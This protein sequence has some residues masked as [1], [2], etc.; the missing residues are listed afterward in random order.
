MFVHVVQALSSSPLV[1]LYT[2]HMHAAGAHAKM[3]RA[4]S[5]GAESRSGAV[6][7]AAFLAT[8]RFVN[9]DPQQRAALAAAAAVGESGEQ[10]VLNPRR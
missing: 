10:R 4:A 2:N 9:V 6:E 1:R 8:P 5:G 3:R 7:D